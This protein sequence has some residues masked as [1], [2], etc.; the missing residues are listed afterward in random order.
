MRGVL[1]RRVPAETGTLPAVPRLLLVRKRRAPS[2]VTAVTVP[3]AGR[4]RVAGRLGDG[5]VGLALRRRRSGEAAR[6]EVVRYG[7]DF[8]ATVDVG[9]LPA[10]AATW[11][12]SAVRVDGSLERLPAPAAG[13][14]PGVRRVRT[15]S[16]VYAYRAFATVKG[17]LSIEVR[18]REPA[19]HAEVTRVLLRGRAVEVEGSDPAF[20]GARLVATAREG[21]AE[22]SAPVRVD[23]AHFSVALDLAGL[24]VA[25]G[26]AGVWDLFLESSGERLRLGAHRD[27]VVDKHNTVVFP[28]AE[29]DGWFLRPYFT[30]AN[31]LSIRARPLAAEG[32]EEAPLADEEAEEAAAHAGAAP[33]PLERVAAWRLGR[34][35]RRGR[36]RGGRRRGR[37]HI[38]LGHAFGM[39]GTI[40]TTLNLAGFLAR[41]HEVEVISVVRRADVPFI[42]FPPGVAV[43]VVDDQRSGAPA[44]PSVLVHP[45]EH[46]AGMATLRTDRLL[47]RRLR[48]LRSGVVIAT[49]PALSIPA[50]RLVRRGVA[51]VAQEH[52]PLGGYGEAVAGQ[53]R[54]AYPSLDALAV[55]TDDDV[56][57]YRAALDPAPPIRRIRNPLPPLPGGV[58][59]LTAPVA[60]A[61]GRLV[62]VKGFDLLVPAFGAVVRRHPEWR[63]RIFGGGRPFRFHALRRIVFEHE[64]YNEVLLMGRTDRLGEEMAR[65]SLFVLSSRFEGLPMVIIEAMSKGLPV[66]AFDCPTG[67]REMID[68]G[69]DG[70]LVPEGDVAA[71]GEAI[72]ELIADPAR[73]R[74]YGA[75]ALEKARSYDVDVIGRQWE[76]LLGELARR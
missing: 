45:D 41:T 7:S 20:T 66:V 34:L 16:A 73:R 3:E 30:E 33:G 39:G 37:V 53:Q 71:L 26:D 5:A 17:N 43:T 29:V 65:A 32:D 59:P 67:P 22:V 46:F 60:I 11:D 36:R 42:P 8:A 35:M 38:V 74:R 23:G 18:A 14:L 9:A 54:W 64:L 40:R 63:L 75:A 56:R 76:E 57:S 69:V 21:A 31:N 48:S 49:R 4:L 10:Q 13:S 2:V 28:R 44:P 24:V 6:L 52:V 50:A 62:P 68:D 58:S 47:A 25:V 72:C 1:S 70:T 61:A 19:P 15:P 12:L 27:G 51:V 55:L